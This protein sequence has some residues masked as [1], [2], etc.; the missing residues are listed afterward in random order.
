MDEVFS[1]EYRQKI[2]CYVTNIDSNIFALKNLPEVIKGALFSR[3]SRSNLGLRELL[4][5]EFVAGDDEAAFA[6]I[7]GF[8]EGQENAIKKAQS[9]YD[10]VLDGF[11]DDSIGE[12]GG[13]HIAV[14]DISMMAAKIIED[15][16]IGGS[17]LE[18]STRYLFFDRKV[19]GEYR[20]YKEPILMAS[21]Y[22]EKYLETCNMLFDTYSNLIA[23]L[24]E[25]FEVLIPQT[26]EVS[27]KAYRSSIR[28]KV[29]DCLRGLLP[30]SALTNVGLY[31][32]GRF[33]DGLVR[34]LNCH[35]LAEMQ[36]IGKKSFD[37]L[38]KIIPSFIRRSSADHANFK[39]YADFYSSMQAEI[40]IITERCLTNKSKSNVEA[41]VRLVDCDDDA[42]VKVVAALLFAGSQ[43]DL[44]TLR[45]TVREMDPEQATMILEAACNTRGNR[46]HKSPRALENAYFTFELVSD[47]GCYRDLQRHRI[48]TQER[49]LLSCDYSYVV[50][51]EIKGTSVEKEYCAAL[52]KAKKAYD[53]IVQEFPEE[54]QYVIPMAYNIRW[55]FNINLRALQW[56]C[57]LR[58]IAAGHSNY[59]TIA[60][61]MAR[62]V[63]ERFPAF[64]CAFKFVDYEDYGL[65]RLAQEQKITAGKKS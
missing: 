22:R 46:R 65:G 34:K 13:A 43:S 37:E 45:D 11:G 50:P 40:K 61:N 4:F 54:A 8:V 14:E 33:F 5:K 2:S 63:C 56:V 41:G 19:N 52:D 6:D 1:E 57:E 17:P 47:F 36:D 9:F 31:G 39:E 7:A 28:A 49:Q 23:P 38:S 30:T 51:E 26:T 27:E 10:R 62:A 48:L 55:Y 29:L 12:L 20:F 21:A 18:K 15:S 32:N 53:E 60:Q 25:H 42:V 24:T 16:R 3:Y 64:E 58:S 44:K 59:R 35:N